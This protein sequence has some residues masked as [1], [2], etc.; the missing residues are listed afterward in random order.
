MF[1]FGPKNREIV[2]YV[3]IISLLGAFIALVIAGL[4]VYPRQTAEFL[5]TLAG[6]AMAGYAVGCVLK[7]LM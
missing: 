3:V 6:G 5:G 2:A 4:I 1:W 7:K